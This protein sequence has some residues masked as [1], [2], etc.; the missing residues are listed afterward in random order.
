VHT[1]TPPPD[2]TDLGA[3]RFPE[4]VAAR[5]HTVVLVEG[6]S[7]KLALGAL[8][9][10]RERDLDA[11]GIAVLAMG[12]SKN[13]R[14]FLEVFGPQGIGLG[15]AGLCDAAEEGD[16]R[17]ALERAGFG[18]NLGRPDMESLGFQV[19]VADLEDEL[20]RALGADAVERVLAAHGELPALRSFQRQPQWASRGREEQLRRF[21]GTHSGRKIECAPLLVRALELD[22]VPAPLDRLLTQLPAR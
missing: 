16:Y 6:M 22:R 1:G 14:R 19:C 4:T 20:I 3:L 7:D 18:T 17:R 11:E 13:V 9:A 5:A 15:M 12:G 2:V 10:R 8:A 21:L